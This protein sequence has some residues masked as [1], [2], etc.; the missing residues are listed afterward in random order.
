MSRENEMKFWEWLAAGPPWMPVALGMAI[1]FDVLFILNLVSGPRRAPTALEAVPEVASSSSPPPRG[2][3]SS[4]TSRVIY[5]KETRHRT[6]GFLTFHPIDKNSLG[7]VLTVP[8]ILRGDD[9]VGLRTLL[10]CAD[11]R[12]AEE[13]R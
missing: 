12:A 3:P 7:V 11:S 9:L 1:V 13:P 6:E 2:A 5:M 8:A 10:G 4:P